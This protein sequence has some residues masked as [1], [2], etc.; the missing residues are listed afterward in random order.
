MA[1]KESAAE[2][3]AQAQREYAAGA[4]QRDPVAV[5]TGTAAAAKH[6][7]QG[8]QAEAVNRR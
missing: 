7:V 3:V 6:L 5:Q 2:L 1:A 4:A 8:Q